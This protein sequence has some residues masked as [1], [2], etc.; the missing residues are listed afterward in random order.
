[1]RPDL[2]SLAELTLW[3]GACNNIEETNKEEKSWWT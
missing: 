1:V 3:L 2:L